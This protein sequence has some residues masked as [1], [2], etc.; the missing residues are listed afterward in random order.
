MDIE[1]IKE[2]ATDVNWTAYQV[3]Y[4]DGLGAYAWWKDGVQYV[5]NC[6]TTL[7]EALE[8]FGKLKENE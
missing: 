4:K 7:K 2:L 6:G 1:Q 8:K 5:G 3:G